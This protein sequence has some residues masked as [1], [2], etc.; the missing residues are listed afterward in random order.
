MAGVPVLSLDASWWGLCGGMTFLTRDIVEAGQ[1]QLGARDSSK[2]PLVLAQ[3]LLRRQ[4]DSIKGAAMITRWLTAIWQRDHGTRLWG[5]SLAQVTTAECFS[6]MQDIDAG[7]LCPIGLITPRRW[8]PW[9]VFRN[10][11]VLV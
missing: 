10:H 2:I 8:I 11:V 1:P 5:R 6:I 4:I 3:H 7:R 9:D